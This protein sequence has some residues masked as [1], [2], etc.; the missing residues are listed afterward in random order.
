MA[1]YGNGLHRRRYLNTYSMLNVISAQG[2]MGRH[3]R[4]ESLFYRQVLGIS[5]RDEFAIYQK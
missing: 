1:V 3:K 5:I 4:G 2:G